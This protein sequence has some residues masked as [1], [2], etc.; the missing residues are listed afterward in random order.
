MKEKEQ[1]NIDIIVSSSEIPTFTPEE[2]DDREYEII[3]EN[4]QGGL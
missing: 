2:A 3:E 4:G 1:N